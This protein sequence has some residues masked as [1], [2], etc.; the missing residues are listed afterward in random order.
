MKGSIKKNKGN[1]STMKQFSDKRKRVDDDKVSRCSKRQR[2]HPITTDTEH[3]DEV[4]PR[5]KGSAAK[6]IQICSNLEED[7]KAIIE[8]VGFQGLLDIKCT[9]VP[10]KLSKWLVTIFDL[11][12]SELIVPERGTIPVD[13]VAVQRMFGIPMGRD[14]VDAKLV[15]G[16]QTY[17]TFQQVFG[18]NSGRAPSVTS[19]ESQ[20]AQMKK[21]DDKFLQYWMV[22]CLSTFLCPTTSPSINI[23]FFQPVVNVNEIKNLKW[24][25][26]IVEKIKKGISS[27]RD[28]PNKKT[29]SGCLLFLTL[30]YLDSLE[31]GNIVDREAKVRASVWTNNLVKKVIKMDQIS[32]NKYGK[33][34]LKREFQ[35]STHLVLGN[36]HGLQTFI[37]MNVPQGYSNK[38]NCTL[39]KSQLGT[40][41]PAIGRKKKLARAVSTLRTGFVNLITDFVRTISHANVADPTSSDESSGKQNTESEDSAPTSSHEPSG[42]QDTESEDSAPTSSHEPSGNQDTDNEDNIGSDEDNTDGDEHDGS[43]ERKDDD[44]EAH[45]S[46]RDDEEEVHSEKSNIERDDEEEVHSD[47]SK[48]EGDD[49]D[50]AH[51]DKRKTERDDEEEV[52]S[53]QFRTPPRHK[54]ELSGDIFDTLSPLHTSNHVF[55]SQNYHFMSEKTKNPDAR[56]NEGLHGDEHII[57]SITQEVMM[58]TTREA[59]ETTKT[60]HPGFKKTLN[61]VSPSFDIQNPAVIECTFKMTEIFNKVVRYAKG[62]DRK[63]INFGPDS[64]F[65]TLGE[66]ASSIKGR[67]RLTDVVADIVVATYADSMKARRKKVWNPYA[68]G[69]M[70]KND[71]NRNLV[72]K[73]FEVNEDDCLDKAYDMIMVPVLEPSKEKEATF[74]HWFAIAI[75]FKSKCFQIFDSIRSKKDVDL[76]NTC[77]QLIS[78]IKSL[79]KQNF[80]TAESTTRSLD[81]FDIQY[82]DI[83]FQTNSFD[84]GYYMLAFIDLW[85]GKKMPLFISNNVPK[86]RKKLLYDM[87]TSERNIVDWKE[88]LNISSD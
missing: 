3:V 13:E 74:G 78:T 65:I 34:K 79:W 22:F 15:K 58:L 53:E 11:E 12:K 83:R 56:T 32:A 17:K 70:L 77:Q 38:V 31:V 82:L 30:L 9:F 49:K 1:Y 86:M 24:C 88:M 68:A 28:N 16:S 23:N 41:M 75:N 50:A 25:K 36:D 26:L 73:C 19:I 63:V 64:V 76:V 29:I 84:C 27:F 47:K 35:D 46:V 54:N 87:L 2:K 62:D 61:D 67:G 51:S 55:S 39:N 80:D 48:T 37:N 60:Q 14:D 5:K 72:K 33:L 44:S 42:N 81:D 85:T 18:Y 66:L 10:E 59:K 21:G 43:D 69:L 71:L 20:L 8:K 7:Q 6:L 45:S 52:Q 4:N 40:L 57:D